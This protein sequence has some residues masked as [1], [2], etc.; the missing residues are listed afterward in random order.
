MRSIS[1]S[2]LA[3][4]I[5][6]FMLPTAAAQTSGGDDLPAQREF[7]I[8]L[9]HDGE[10]GEPNFADPLVA[11]LD[12]G[13]HNLRSLVAWF[14]VDPATYEP[15]L[16]LRLVWQGGDYSKG[17]IRDEF[18]MVVNG[19]RKA[20]HVDSSDGETFTTTFDGIGVPTEPDENGIQIMDMWVRYSA[21]GGGP[22]DEVT[23]LMVVSTF[24]H[25]N[26]DVMPG[27]WYFHDQEMQWVAQHW[28]GGA[29]FTLEKPATHLVVTAPGETPRI[30]ADGSS[31]LATVT[32]NN[33]LRATQQEARF[34][35]ETPPELMGSLMGE[36]ASVSAGGSQELQMTL[37]L[38][39]AGNMTTHDVVYVNRT[40]V[41]RAA[42][43]VGFGG[44][45]EVPVMVPTFVPKPPMASAQ[46][47]KQGI[48]GPAPA[49]AF[50]AL[51]AVASC[52]R[53]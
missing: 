11:P 20:F 37:H 3:S 13:G 17:S 2:M 46:E 35:I 19:E 50:L 16:Y 27:G 51:A 36:R 47:E 44:T 12:E 1:P 6:A 10:E 8:F 49:L 29:N 30:P 24:D 32:V 4:A 38:H 23:D 25:H 53:R 9:L 48:P 34:T 41:I 14:G 18:S 15:A 21:L 40:V 33:G 39:Q 22:G 42:S 52:R 7:E 43:D 45:T 5:L 31:L 26:R 28:P